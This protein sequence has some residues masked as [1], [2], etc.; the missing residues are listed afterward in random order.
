MRCAY[1]GE[2]I[3]CGEVYYEIEGDSIHRDCI[4]DYLDEFYSLDDDTYEVED[5]TITRDELDDYLIDHMHTCYEKEELG[6]PRYEPEYWE[7]R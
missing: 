4:Q 7:D 1:C 2:P 3:E 6:D 5:E